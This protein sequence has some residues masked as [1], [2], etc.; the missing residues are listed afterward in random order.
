MGLTGERSWDQRAAAHAYNQNEVIEA[1]PVRSVAILYDK[2]IEAL[3]H[4]IRAI[5]ENDINKRYLS[6]KRAA[7]ILVGLAASLDM[8]KGGEIADNLGRLYKFMLLRL[9]QVDV[10]N[11]AQ[12]ARDVIGLLDPLR[13][14]WHQLADQMEKEESQNL[15][16]RAGPGAAPGAYAQAAQ[17]A[18]GAPQNPPQGQ[19]SSSTAPSA[20]PEGDPATRPG[21]EIVV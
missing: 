12:S 17:T 15:P 14:S 8:E 20:A 18:Q 2:A 9:M 5:E 4:A 13:R 6:N 21:V 10:N 16:T 11:D 19:E 3:H 7:D 1:P